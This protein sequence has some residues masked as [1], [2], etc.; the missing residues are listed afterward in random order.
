VKQFLSTERRDCMTS[1]DQHQDLTDPALWARFAAW[2]A[3]RSRR[4]WSVG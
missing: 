2:I 3:A 4:R 1:L